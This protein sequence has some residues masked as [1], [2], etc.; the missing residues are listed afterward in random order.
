MAHF[1]LTPDAQSDLIEIRHYTQQQWDDAQSKKYLTELRQTIHLL[2]K[3]PS[4]GESRP[5]IGID[6][7]SF[8]HVSH[9]IYCVIHEQ[10]LVVFSVLHKR[11]V[12]L[13]HLMDR[14]IP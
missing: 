8:L 3:T 2:A 12:P 7:L 10:E 9:V 11:M 13:N 14:E 4:I 6:I 5:D 1:R